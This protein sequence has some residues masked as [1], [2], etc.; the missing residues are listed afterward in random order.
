MDLELKGKVAIVTGGSKGIGLGI[1]G[2]LLAEGAHVVNVNR[3]EA[4]GLQLEREAAAAGQQC[5]FVQGDLSDT[6]SCHRAVEKTLQAFGR[7]DILVNNAGVNDGVG[8]DAGVDAFLD[9]LRRNLIHYY[10]MAHYALNALKKSRGVI[11]N[12]GSKVCETGQGGTSGYAASKGGINGLTREWAV[13]LAPH[14]VRVNAV[15][16]AETWTPL[17]EKCLAA[18]PDPAGAKAHLEELIPLGR[19]FTT[20]EELADMA[21]FLASPRSSHTT[22]QII[23]VDGGYTHLDRKCT[24]RDVSTFGAAANS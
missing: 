18:M 8:L 7:I 21:V 15:L 9:S 17:Y 20:I 4:E 16:P 5:L 22:G 19:R 1:V 14:G 2:R 3:S 13:D 11:I 23:F 12:I 24:V 10:A 6:T